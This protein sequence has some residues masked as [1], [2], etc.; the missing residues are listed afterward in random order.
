MEADLKRRTKTFALRII[1]LYS[2]MP[3][4]GPAQVLGIQVLKSGTS[5]GAHYREATEQSR[6]LTLSV[7]LKVPFKNLTKHNIGW[8]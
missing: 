2:A 7:K 6:M 1:R 4:R 8:S 3:R 5:P